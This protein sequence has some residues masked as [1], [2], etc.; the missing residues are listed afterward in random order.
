MEPI[1]II[2]II[3]SLVLVLDAQMYFLF[4]SR[5]RPVVMAGLS[6]PGEKVAGLVGVV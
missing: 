5:S 4:F 3:K 1:I 2:I 6:K